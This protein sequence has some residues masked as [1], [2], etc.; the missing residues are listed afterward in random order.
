VYLNSGAPLSQ[1]K[2]NL[3]NINRDLSQ[4][5]SVPGNKMQEQSDTQGEGSRTSYQLPQPNQINE[6]E[7]LDLQH[8]LFLMTLNGNLYRAPLKESI[9]NA[10]DIGTGSG[11]WAVGK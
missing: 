3:N 11:I 1:F 9:S 8:E 10:L 2:A 6:R 7:R 4:K 5:F